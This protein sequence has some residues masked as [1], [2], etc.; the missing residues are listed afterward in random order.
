VDAIEVRDGPRAGIATLARA[1]SDL[2][3]QHLTVRALSLN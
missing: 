1:S 2:R 3:N